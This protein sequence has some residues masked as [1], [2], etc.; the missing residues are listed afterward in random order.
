MRGEPGTQREAIPLN[1]QLLGAATHACPSAAERTPPCALTQ[2][3]CPRRG[4][5]QPRSPRAGDAAPPRRS[6]LGQDPTCTWKPARVAQRP[7]VGFG[8]E[9]DASTL[10]SL[11][12]LS[13]PQPPGCLRQCWSHRPSHLLSH[14][15]M[16]HPQG[17]MGAEINPRQFLM[18]MLIRQWVY[19]NNKSGQLLL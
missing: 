3:D 14:A 15:G 7:S 12:L 5:Q 9:E 18:Q 19:K 2:R 4:M 13:C 10:R 17:M 1:S 16:T 8:V 11:T 6:A